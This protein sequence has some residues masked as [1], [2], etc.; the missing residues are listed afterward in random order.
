MTQEFIAALRK[1]QK[2]REKFVA[3]QREALFAWEKENLTPLVKTCDHEYP[4]GESAL[5]SGYSYTYR[6]CCICGK[7]DRS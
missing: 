2:E 7:A 5:R 4:W 1:A 6:Q 3:D